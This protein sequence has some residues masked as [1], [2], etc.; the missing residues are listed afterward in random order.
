MTTR[1][2]WQKVR[3]L[4]RLGTKMLL[5][6]VSSTRATVCI[7]HNIRAARWL[8]LFEARGVLR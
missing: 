3:F 7:F 5:D 6:K 2:K 4:G 8:R 1:R